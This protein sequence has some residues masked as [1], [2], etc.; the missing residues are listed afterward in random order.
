MLIPVAPD[1]PIL[2]ANVITQSLYVPDPVA[3]S[4]LTENDVPLYENTIPS[5]YVF[6]GFALD[7]ILALVP[8][9]N[10]DCVASRSTANTLLLATLTEV[11]VEEVKLNDGPVAPVAPIGPVEPVAPV[12]PKPVIP[13]SPVA[14]CT[15]VAPVDP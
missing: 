13:V 3:L 2:P 15:P 10:A 8:T 7:A 5:M 4:V 9:L 12:A 11:N 14:P 6:V 1:A